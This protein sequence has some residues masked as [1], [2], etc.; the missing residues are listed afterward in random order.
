[1]DDCNRVAALRRL[2]ASLPALFLFACASSPPE[3]AATNAVEPTD[4]AAIVAA[5]DAKTVDATELDT[6]LI[7]ERSAPTGSRI[8]EE[9]CYSKE[10]YAQWQAM[11]QETI[12][13][14]VNDMRELQRTRELAE[15]AARREAMERA[16]RGGF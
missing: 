5:N 12:K 14:D 6:G 11:Q 2:S 15:Q 9:Q 16:L 1:M 10:E 7:C 13:R 4:P 3:T 8:A